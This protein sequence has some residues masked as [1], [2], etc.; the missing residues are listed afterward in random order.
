MKMTDIEVLLNDEDDGGEIVL[1]Q[2]Q[3]SIVSIIRILPEQAKLVCEW[4]MACKKE[5]DNE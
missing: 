4:V 3:D 2:R 1:C 5:R